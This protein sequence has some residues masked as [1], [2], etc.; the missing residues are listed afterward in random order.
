MSNAVFDGVRTILAVREYRADELP[1][2][3][4]ERCVEAGHLSGSSMNGQPWHFILVRDRATL[5]DLGSLAPSGPYI[6]G[7]AAAIVVAIEKASR[8]GVSDASRAIQSIML[9]AWADGVGSNWVGFG[10]LERVGA[11]LGVP[12]THEVLAVVPLG[13]PVRPIGKGRKDRRPLGEMAS[14][15]R[16]GTPLSFG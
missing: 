13:Y 16:F 14:S 1:Q 15:E 2:E 6:A 4:L 9:T 8:F 7:A 5:R 10:G 12:E 3:V 11:A